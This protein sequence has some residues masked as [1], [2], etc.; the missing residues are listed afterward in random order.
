MHS[1]LSLCQG[2]LNCSLQGQAASHNTRVKDA[3]KES[4][5]ARVESSASYSR[6]L[7]WIA[8]LLGTLTVQDLKPDPHSAFGS[9]W[10]QDQT[11]IT[12]GLR[13]NINGD[14]ELH[15]I[16]STVLSSITNLLAFSSVIYP[17]GV[18][19]IQIPESSWK[20]TF[21]TGLW[22]GTIAQR[23]K[24]GKKTQKV[25]SKVQKQNPVS[26]SKALMLHVHSP[27]L[28]ASENICV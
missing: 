9:F 21:T 2:L 6:G 22:P 8:L 12:Y 24:K 19:W 1:S 23:S 15:F 28:Y 3:L 7:K 27:S 5:L 25:P 10:W 13:E 16:V 11:C 4:L 14:V 17:A 18:T 26:Q 20:K